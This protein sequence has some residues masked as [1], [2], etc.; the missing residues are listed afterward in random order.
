MLIWPERERDREETALEEGETTAMGAE[1]PQV[2]DVEEEEQVVV[3]SVGPAYSSK[4]LTS[5]LMLTR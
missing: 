5:I 4:I 3:A 2:E 1:L